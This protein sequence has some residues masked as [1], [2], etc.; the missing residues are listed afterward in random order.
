MSEPDQLLVR[1]RLSP[2]AYKAFRSAKPPAASRTLGWEAWL[3]DKRYHGPPI[4]LAE[5]ESKYCQYRETSIDGFLRAVVESDDS[6]FALDQYDLAREEWTYRVLDYS[7]NYGD[8]IK[9]LNVLQSAAAF[10]DRPALDHAL[11]FGH[12]YENSKLVA[13][14][15]IGVGESTFV[16]ELD[17]EAL[18]FIE[19]AKVAIDEVIG[20][21]E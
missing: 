18:E 3:S 5:I 16:S 12:F 13:L 4:G 1:A 14:L 10:K 19:R 11:I 6:G 7:E 9:M 2:T 15:R 17:D 8:F 21:H 20:A